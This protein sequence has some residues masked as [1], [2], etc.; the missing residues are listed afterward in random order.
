MPVTPP[1]VCCDAAAVCGPGEQQISDPAECPAGASCRRVQVCCDTIWCATFEEPQCDGLPACNGGDEEITG[2]CPASAE[3]YSRTLCGAT[4]QCVV[5]AADCQW[6]DDYNRQY[7]GRSADECAVVRFACDEHTEAFFDEC[8]CGCE[9][10]ADC[11]P[12]S[13][14]APMGSIEPDGCFDERCPFSRF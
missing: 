4:I 10:A 3:C 7:A 1:E 8:G 5:T 11:P 6:D 14:C 9:Q 2:E 12:R 13:A